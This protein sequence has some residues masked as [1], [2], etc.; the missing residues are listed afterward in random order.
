MAGYI[1]ACLHEDEHFPLRP[2]VQKKLDVL[3]KAGLTNQ[4]NFSDAD[5]KRLKVYLV[6]PLDT[7]TAYCVGHL[8]LC[9]I[10]CTM[11]GKEVWSKFLLCKFL[12]QH[13]TSASVLLG[14]PATMS[15]TIMLVFS[16]LQ[17]EGPAGIL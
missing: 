3:G 10:M 11:S 15:Q 6:M 7:L 2:L 9:S 17:A 16:G 4:D 13:F 8:Q 14:F 1:A 12:A 5:T